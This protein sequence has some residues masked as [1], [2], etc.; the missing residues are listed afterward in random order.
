MVLGVLS[1][2]LSSEKKSGI[3]SGGASAIFASANLGTQV[4]YAFCG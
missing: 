4:P 3:I 1:E 2:H